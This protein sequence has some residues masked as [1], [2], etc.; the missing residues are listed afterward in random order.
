MRLE[1]GRAVHEWLDRE[2]EERGAALYAALFSIVDGTWSVLYDHWDEPR[3]QGMALEFLPGEI[4]IW[5]P[6]PSD[7][8]RFHVAYIGDRPL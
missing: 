7:P 5:R 2:P 8:D 1:W 6:Y 4:V 3:I